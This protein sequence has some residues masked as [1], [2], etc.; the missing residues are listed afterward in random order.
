MADTDRMVNITQGEFK[1]FISENRCRIGESEERMVREDSPQSHSTGM[2]DS[3]STKA[4]QTCMT[5]NNINILSNNNV[6]EY[7]EEREDGREGR[8]TVDDEEWD[9]VDLET[10]REVTN[11]GASFV[12]MRNDNHFVT[13][14]YEFLE[15]IRRGGVTI[16]MERLLRTIGRCDSQFHLKES[17][18]R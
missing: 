6:P 13:A 4:T 18:L 15:A 3:F 1:Q 14:V 16:G 7:G 17:V 5:V 12:C 10:V 8:L 11:S 9:V 2:E